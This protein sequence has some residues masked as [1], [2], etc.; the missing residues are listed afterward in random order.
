MICFS[1]QH[2]RC[3]VFKISIDFESL[4]SEKPLLLNIIHTSFWRLYCYLFIHNYLS[5]KTAALTILSESRLSEVAWVPFG[6]FFDAVLREDSI[7]A[8]SS[9]YEQTSQQRSKTR[10]KLRP[11]LWSLLLARSW[12]RPCEPMALRM[13]P[14]ET[15][16]LNVLLYVTLDLKPTWL[17]VTTDYKICAGPLNLHPSCSFPCGSVDGVITAG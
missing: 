2:S 6:Y 12:L 17:L 15:H 10:S 9:F 14:R 5:L 11:F 1:G 7:P 8:F 13:P 4:S 16:V 3:R